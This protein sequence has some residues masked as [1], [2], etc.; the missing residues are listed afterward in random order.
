MSN[1]YTSIANPTES[2]EPLRDGLQGNQTVA[3]SHAELDE[4][5]SRDT[6]GLRKAGSLKGAPNVLGLLGR[7]GIARDLLEPRIQ[8]WIQERLSSL[9]P[10][11]RAAAR[12]V[13]QPFPEPTKCSASYAFSEPFL[14][15]LMTLH[16]FD[17]SFYRLSPLTDSGQSL[18]RRARGS[19]SPREAKAFALDLLV[20]PVSCYKPVYQTQPAYLPQPAPLDMATMRW[21]RRSSQRQSIPQFTLPPRRLLHFLMVG[22]RRLRDEF[23]R[24]KNRPST[25]P[26][27]S[28]LKRPAHTSEV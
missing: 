10:N 8:P 15:S 7:V 11:S 18:D 17:S 16:T 4:R 25:A 28:P 9:V 20:L 13:G 1:P 27:R 24:L 3:T 19:R 2:L 22:Q 12:P 5:H 23:T 14:T 6:K 21:P 26:P